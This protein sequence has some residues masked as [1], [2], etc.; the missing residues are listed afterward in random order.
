MSCYVNFFMRRGEKFFPI[1]SYSRNHNIFKAFDNYAPW[2][3]IRPL[4]VA[5]LEQIENECSQ[6]KAECERRI[7]GKEKKKQLVAS[8]NNSVEEKYEIICDLDDSIEE[9]NQERADEEMAEHF[10]IFLENMIDEIRYGESNEG[11]D[12]NAYLYVGIE[13]SNPTLNNIK[14]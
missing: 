9:L 11:V 12:P 13:I 14:E 8:F 4:T 10:C 7:E 2:E 3:K 6:M 5:A 1:G